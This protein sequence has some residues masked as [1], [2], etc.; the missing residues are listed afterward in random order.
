[1]LLGHVPARISRTLPLTVVLLLCGTVLGF[2][3]AVST[4]TESSIL[5]PPTPEE[6]TLLV[7]RFAAEKAGA[8]QKRLN[9]KD[10]TITIAVLRTTALKPNTVGNI[11]WDREKKTATIAVLDPADYKMTFE[12]M[13]KDIEFTVVHELIHLEISPVLSDLKRTTENRMEEEHAVNHMADALLK[14]DRGQ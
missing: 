4:P 13:L 9:L 14:L 7:E 6:R 5:E 11:H 10:W 8:W 3:Q 2:S 12:A 1:M